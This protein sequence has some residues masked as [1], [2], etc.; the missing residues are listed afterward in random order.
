[1]LVKQRTVRRGREGKE[2]VRKSPRRSILLYSISISVALKMSL[3][4]KKTS[5][6]A[7]STLMLLY[8]LI[9]PFAHCHNKN[10]CIQQQQYDYAQ[11]PT[12]GQYAAYNSTADNSITHAHKGRAETVSR[13]VYPHCHTH[14]STH[15]MSILFSSGLYL[16]FLRVPALVLRPPSYL[17]PTPTELSLL[18]ACLEFSWC[19][20]GPEWGT[21][22]TSQH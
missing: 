4:E 15:T 2:R 10:K 13:W 17:H 1:M 21:K 8:C 7:L 12:Q 3:W 9:I 19:L 18:F 5:A 16:V 14:M 22:H 11:T 6:L 20:R